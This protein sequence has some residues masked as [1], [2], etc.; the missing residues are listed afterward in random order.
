VSCVI[1]AARTRLVTGPR[2][3]DAVAG[4]ALSASAVDAFSTERLFVGSVTPAAF[5]AHVVDEVAGEPSIL[6]NAMSGEASG[7]THPG[8]AI[9]GCANDTLAMSASCEGHEL[10]CDVDTTPSFA[11]PMLK[12]VPIAI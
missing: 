6:L 9:S 8:A 12:L 5:G 1:P 11:H 2:P 3:A 7:G 4:V 10:S